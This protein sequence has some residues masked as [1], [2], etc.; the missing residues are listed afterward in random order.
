MIGICPYGWQ[1]GL[2]DPLRGKRI[3]RGNRDKPPV[4]G[5]FRVAARYRCRPTLDTGPPW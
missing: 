2:N 1:L 3:G 5:Y 4:I